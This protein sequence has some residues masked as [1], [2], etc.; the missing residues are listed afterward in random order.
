[1]LILK[2]ANMHTIKYKIRLV[3]VLFTL[4]LLF[5]S[6]CKTTDVSSSAP[7]VST[8][9]PVFERTLSTITVPININV[10]QVETMLNQQL[11]G[12]LFKDDD[13][14]GDNLKFTVTK[15]RNFVLSANSN[16]LSANIPLHIWAYG[17]Y[18]AGSWLPT[19]RGEK[20]LEVIVKIQSILTVTP[21]WHIKPYTTINYEW[22]KGKEPTIDVGP[23]SI[24][25]RKYVDYFLDPEK[26]KIANMMDQEI[27]KRVSI[28]DYVQ[29][30][31]N[32]MQAP[33]QVDAATNTWISLS[34]Q[35]IRISPIQCANDKVTAKVSIKS[36]IETLV[37]A[38][39]LQVTNTKLPALIVDSKLDDNFQVGLIGEIS[40][41]TATDMIKKEVI[42]KTYSFENGK[43]QLQIDDIELSGNDSKLM[44]RLDIQGKVRKGARKKIKGRVYLQGTPYYDDVTQAIRIKDFDYDVSTRNVLAKSAAWVAKVGFSSKIK[45]YLN[46][47][48]KDKIEDAKKMVQASLNNNTRLMNNVYMKG[49]LTSLKPGNIYITPTS[50]KAVVNAEGSVSISIDK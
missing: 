50:L 5:F 44:I 45:E 8:P 32:Q 47:P 29:Q 26:A 24:P 42:G 43:Y 19:V 36:Y 4:S 15:L 30:A 18:D 46:F 10:K 41:A 3:A 35:E 20:N 27:S 17:E 16:R 33:M 31:W 34:P 48:V 38:K 7:P 13:L 12:V 11:N 14:K 21:D 2:S 28:K 1:M 37:G 39:P 23:M 49:N 9:A 25:I 40:Y 22:E 6:S